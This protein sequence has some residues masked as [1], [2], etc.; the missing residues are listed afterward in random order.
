LKGQYSAELLSKL[1]GDKRKRFTSE[2]N[3]IESKNEKGDLIL[4][5][6]PLKKRQVKAN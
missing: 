3:I 5:Q 6:V 2:K 4:R 1:S